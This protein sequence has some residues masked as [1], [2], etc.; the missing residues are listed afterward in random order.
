MHHI[1]SLSPIL[2]PSFSLY[3]ARLASLIPGTS[4]H[5]E[6]PYYRCVIQLSLH[7]ERKKGTIMR[8]KGT[9]IQLVYI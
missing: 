6:I 9:H 5:H 1:T 3:C 7:T 4:L 2:L 8:P